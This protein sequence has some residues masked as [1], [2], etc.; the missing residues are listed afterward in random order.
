MSIPRAFP[1]VVFQTLP[2]FGEPHGSEGAGQLSR[3]LPFNLDLSMFSRDERSHPCFQEAEHG[4]EVDSTGSRHTHHRSLGASPSVPTPP[5]GAVHSRTRH[6]AGDAL[7]GPALQHATFRLSPV[8][9]LRPPAHSVLST[10]THAL[11]ASLGL[12]LRTDLSGRGSSSWG[13]PHSRLLS[14]CSWSGLLS[15]HQRL[16]QAPGAD[17][18][19]VWARPGPPLSARD[20]EESLPKGDR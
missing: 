19:Q 9:A 8:P 12:P 20:S 10:L 4:G 16:P 13:S 11:L 15:A 2:A 17:S 5:P 14:H 6:S 7:Q 18:L 1:C 3:R